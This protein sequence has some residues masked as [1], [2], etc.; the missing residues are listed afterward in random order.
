MR[1]DRDCDGESLAVS[2]RFPYDPAIPY[3][4]LGDS[5]RSPCGWIA[6]CHLILENLDVSSHKQPTFS[7]VSELRL[8]LR[9]L[10]FPLIQ[11]GPVEGAGAEV[12]HV[13]VRGEALDRGV[14]QGVVLAEDGT[15]GREQELDVA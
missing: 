5:K 8:P 12:G 7:A 14:E 9:Q 11:Q 1:P 2:G 6:E 4:R 15:V 10:F 3:Q 13:G